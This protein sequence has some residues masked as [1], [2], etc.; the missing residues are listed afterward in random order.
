MIQNVNMLSGREINEEKIGF[1]IVPKRIKEITENKGRNDCVE[2]E[3][4]STKGN[5]RKIL[6]IRNVYQGIKK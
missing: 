4:G 2:R 3:K 5:W 6:E 1:H